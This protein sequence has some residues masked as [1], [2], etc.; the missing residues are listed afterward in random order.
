[1]KIIKLFD[2]IIILLYMQIR[3][4][5]LFNFVAR[6][7]LEPSTKVGPDGAELLLP[8]ILYYTP[9]SMAGQNVY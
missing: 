4:N 8:Y 5:Q 7:Y 1:M 3:G 9:D 6:A 2:I